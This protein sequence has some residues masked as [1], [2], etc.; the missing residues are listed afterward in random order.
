M[1]FCLFLLLIIAH[2][3]IGAQESL[4]ADYSIYDP[5]PDPVKHRIASRTIYVNKSSDSIGIAAVDT[6]FEKFD[7]FGRLMSIDYY[8]AKNPSDKSYRILHHFTYDHK[9]RISTDSSMQDT[10]LFVDTYEYSESQ[11]RA[12][13]KTQPYWADSTTATIFNYDRHNN[14]VSKYKTD[15]RGD[16][17]FLSTTNGNTTISVS[18]R[19]DE[20]GALIMVDSVIVNRTATQMTRHAIF[21]HRGSYDSMLEVEYYNKA[22]KLT[23]ELFY[24]DANVLRDS[25]HYVYNRKGLPVSHTSTIFPR[26]IFSD[27]TTITTWH[28]EYIYDKQGRLVKNKNWSDRHP[29]KIYYTYYRY[30]EKGLLTETEN[31]AIYDGRLEKRECERWVYTYY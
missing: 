12:I 28:M 29:E 24:T 7:R 8:E 19:R 23:D 13:I 15:A 11:Q 30:N 22:G 21:I 9:G 14:V 3:T 17:L 25:V 6:C 26:R 1:R 27:D 10:T 18:R 4:R 31:V 5:C 20:N 2:N 16:T